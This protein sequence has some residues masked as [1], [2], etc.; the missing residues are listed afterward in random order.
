MFSFKYRYIFIILLGV[1]SYLNILV[2]GGDRLFG[3]AIPESLFIAIILALVLLIWE[4]N[5]L[6]EN[7]RHKIHWMSLDKINPLVLQFVGS[8]VL[9]SLVA[10][11]PVV[12]LN[13]FYNVAADPMMFPVKLSFGFTFRVNLFLNCVNAIVFYMDKYKQSQLEAEQLK[14]QSIEAR[15]D[16]LRNQINPHFLFNSFNV[17]SSLVYKD[18]DASSKFIEQLSNVYRYLLYN[19]DQKLIRLRDELE[20]ID[21]YIYLLKIRFQ[22]NVS[23]IQRI[24][25]EM[26]EL[27]IAPAT[28]QMLMEN[29]IKH[30]V[31][32]KKNPLE[33][34][35]EVIDSHIEVANN[36]QPKEVKEPSTNLGLQNIRNRYDFLVGKDAVSI[37]N[38]REFVVR[39]PLIE[40]DIKE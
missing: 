20:F 12:A 31:V 37:R 36:F 15:F 33:I 14:K 3:F 29:A 9:V 32:S 34:R 5:R 7:Y 1:Y 27:F 26:K 35:I 2:T 40:L 6:I 4:A 28:L 8:I 17:L 21:S 23:I 24:P 19:Q 10:V 16:A 18:A 38:G 13:R 11:L 30:N 39:I 25:E 22:E